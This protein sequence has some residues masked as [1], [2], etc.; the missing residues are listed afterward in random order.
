M[1]CPVCGEQ[2]QEVERSGVA[3]DACPRCRGIWLDRGELERILDVEARGLQPDPGFGGRPGGV[4]PRYRD[5][6]D[7]HHHRDWDDEH[8][9]NRDDY[10]YGRRRRQGFLGGILE[11]LGGDD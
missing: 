8:G 6:D 7:D 11:R 9:Y 1:K 2:L 5:H 10:R 4:P 3:V